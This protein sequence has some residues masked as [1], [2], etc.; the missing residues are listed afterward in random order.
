MADMSET[1]PKREYPRQKV[2]LDIW[3]RE[4]RPWLLERLRLREWRAADLAK[5]I[6]R[7]QGTV[8]RWLNAQA[9]PSAENCALLAKTFGVDVDTV[10]V[11]AG[12][13]ARQ[14]EANPLIGEVVATLR[15]LP[16]EKQRQ[17]LEVAQAWLWAWQRD[18][19]DGAA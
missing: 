15:Q 10:L 7:P 3:R 1:G 17:V 2:N 4:G 6:K 9:A 16:P 19:K 11:L 8:S 13:R 5:E 14:E 18:R 12:L